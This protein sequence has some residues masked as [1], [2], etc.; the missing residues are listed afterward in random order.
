[1]EEASSGPTRVRRLDY[2]LPEGHIISTVKIYHFWHRESVEIRIDGKPAKITA[3]GRSNVS[4]EEARNDAAERARRTERKIA[5]ELFPKEDYAVDIREEIVLEVDSHNVVTRNRYGARVLNTESVI[6]ID[7]DHHRTTFLETLGFGKRDNKAAIV[8]DLGKV[9]SRPE[10]SALGFRVYET[11][12]GA[13]LIVTGAYLDP[14]SDK[15]IALFSR[16]HADP[17][18][19]K[20]CVKQQCYRARLTPKPGR[21]KQRKIAYRWP[22]DP[23]EFEKAKEWVRE[24]EAASLGFATCRYVK[25]FGKEHPTFGIIAL[26]DEETKARSRLPLA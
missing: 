20:L 16:T 15:G 3:Y 18:F 6:I 4:V 22:M 7:I 23:D 19:A 14:A 5:G 9:A 17:M 8:E 12:M 25:T 11:F 10:Y 24:Y 21:I 1:M 2:P 26:H 13:R